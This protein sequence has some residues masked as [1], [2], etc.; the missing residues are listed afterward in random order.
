M[1][2]PEFILFGSTHLVGLAAIFTVMIALPKITNKFFSDKR[3][4][5]GRIIG[6]LAIFHTF[7]SPYSDLYLV[8]EPYSWKEVLPLHMCDFSLIFIAIYLLGGNKFFFN[9]A[10]FW[11]IAGA[12]MALLTPDIPYGF[13]SMN[14]L[15][16][17][18]GHGLILYGVFYAVIALNQR[19]Y[20]N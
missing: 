3:E 11:G 19:P 12:S 17:F 8:V 20:F 5:I 18:Y 16:F 6:Y 10:F 13:P 1:E 9:C 2:G 15:M 7:F 14:F 4:L